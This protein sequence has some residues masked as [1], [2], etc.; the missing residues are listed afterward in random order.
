[1]LTFKDL[2]DNNVAPPNYHDDWSTYSCDRFI[3]NY[4]NIFGVV[5]DTNMHKDESGRYIIT[6]SLFKSEDK[7]IE[8]VYAQEWAH[9]KFMD[10]SLHVSSLWTYAVDNYMRLVHEK[11]NGDDVLVC[12]PM[13]DEERQVVDGGKPKENASMTV[14]AYSTTPI[15]SHEY[16]TS[17]K[18]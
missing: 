11:V 7:T 17:F 13:T 6:G 8:F 1:M 5:T 18:Y 10:S 12:I 16:L 9:C 3:V 14:S 15:V 2:I 4:N